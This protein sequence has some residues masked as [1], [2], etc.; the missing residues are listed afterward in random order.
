MGKKKSVALIVLIT[1][2][3][4]GLLFLCITP[5]F[6]VKSPNSFRS[7]LS[8]VDLGRDL[9][10]GYY[11]VYYPEGVISK[12]EYETL[13]A[14]YEYA[15]SETEDGQTP[16][17]DDPSENYVAYRGIY[18]ST[19]ITNEA[20]TD[21]TEEFKSDF[22]N[23]LD[24]I[25]DRYERMGMSDYSI[26]LQD[27]Y[28]IR[29]EVPT[30][31]LESGES[32]YDG[33]TDV[34][35]ML[36]Y[37]SYSGEILFTDAKSASATGTAE[38]AGTS[39]YIRSVSTSN[40]GDQGYAVVINF[41]SAGREAFR[42]LTSSLV[43][44]SSSSDSSSSSS[45]TLYIYVGTHQILGA[46]VSEEMDQDAVYITGGFSKR[47]AEMRAALLNTSISES[48]VF[49]LV[50]ESPEY[51]TTEALL[52]DSTAL[53]AAICIGVLVLAMLVFS[54][55]KFKGMGLAHIYGFI[56]YAVALIACI[57]LIPGIQ[58]T[59]GGI[60]GIL[61]SSA[62][63]VSCNYYAF[64]N[65][66]KE[67][68]TGKTLT[69]SI[70]AG[71]KKSLAF[72]IDVHAILILASLAVWLIATGAAKFMALIFLLGI[73]ISALCTLVITRFYL[74]MFMAQPKNK[75]AFVGFRREETED[76]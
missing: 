24:T 39:E 29:V 75:L 34:Q 40:A 73:A 36:T 53:I 45:A 17:V 59:L 31:I 7:L 2:V 23:A 30:P 63:M 37:F 57:S 11:T 26:Y 27:D 71:Y 14:D 35:E 25:K 76:E 6:P 8:I 18:L 58:L 72:T 19:D 52:G 22:N 21:V 65:I 47:D 38:M 44:S 41:T 9:E 12:A 33:E 69:A 10:G 20:G 54:A 1:V 16:S 67:F 50:F 74:Y 56:T 13:E 5:T 43:S 70:K 64:N 32:A 3:L 62:I 15:L 68:A 46:T 48:D 66:R 61:L 60:I 51:Y 4:V 28:T 49:D 55:V 42:T